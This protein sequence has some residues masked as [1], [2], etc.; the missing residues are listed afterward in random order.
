VSLRKHVF[1]ELFQKNVLYLR[2]VGWRT[3]ESD[4]VVNLVCDEH[5]AF[6]AGMNTIPEIFWIVGQSCV[7]VDRGQA[8]FIRYLLDL[9]DYTLL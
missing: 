2:R 9:W 7:K 1:A 4:S 5:C 6:A 3:V 8:Q